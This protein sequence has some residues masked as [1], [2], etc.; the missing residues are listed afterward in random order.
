MPDT[1]GALKTM[2][3]SIKRKKLGGTELRLK[4][5]P[6]GLLPRWV[7][8]TAT[9]HATVTQLTAE[10]PVPLQEE[11][12]VLKLAFPASFPEVGWPRATSPAGSTGRYIRSRW[13]VISCPSQSARPG[14]CNQDT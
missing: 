6:A 7:I 8:T 2:R 10:T 4:P 3:T 5:R 1:G 9:P 14:L 12:S 13:E 11:P